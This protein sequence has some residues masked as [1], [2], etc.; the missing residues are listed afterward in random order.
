MERIKLKVEGREAKKPNQLR[1]CGKI[2]ATVYG[3]EVESKSFQLAKDNFT[4]LPA[5]AFSQVIEL[6]TPDGSMNALIR[7]VH[8][9]H[10]TSEILNV[11]FYKVATDRKLNVT[12]PLRFVGVAPAVAKGGLLVEMYQYV[13]LECL[14]SEIPEFVE[15][16]V[17]SIEEIEQG[18]HFSQLKTGPGVRIVNPHEELVARVVPKKGGGGSAAAAAAA[19]K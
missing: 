12:V 10:V 14:P 18:V 6:E 3:P 15:V 11:E 2:P 8:R 7:T 4:R 17:S 16:N 1:R 5:A 19:K 13:D 9:K